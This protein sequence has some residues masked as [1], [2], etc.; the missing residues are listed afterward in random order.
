MNKKASSLSSGPRVL[1]ALALGV[2]LAVGI[3]RSAGA[4]ATAPHGEGPAPASAG[5][6]PPP[7]QIVFQCFDANDKPV[8]LPK[9]PLSACQAACP[10]GDHCVRCVIQN[11]AI[12]CP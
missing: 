5:A 10:A 11:N 4:P 3:T 6:L 8:G 12:Q 1:F 7:L 9:S 2:C